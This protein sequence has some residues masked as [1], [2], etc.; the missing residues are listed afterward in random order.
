MIKKLLLLLIIISMYN[1]GMAL[2]AVDEDP[3]DFDNFAIADSVDA[4]VTTTPN[5]INA[6][7]MPATV[8]SFDIAGVMLGMSFDDVYTLFSNGGLYAPRETNAVV[9][10]IT[11]DWRYNLD[12]ECR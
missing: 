7:A 11:P 1:T 4:D 8:S 5:A 2:A 6:G 3:F 10:T 9:Y 12:Y